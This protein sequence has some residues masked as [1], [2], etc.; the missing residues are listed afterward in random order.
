[1]LI[2]TLK[3]EVLQC[4]GLPKLDPLSLTDPYVLVIYNGQT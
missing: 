2:A 1:M 3:V 4:T